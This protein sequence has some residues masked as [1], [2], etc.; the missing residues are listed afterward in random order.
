MKVIFNG[1]LKESGDPSIY[2]SPFGPALEFGQSVFET[3]KV[4]AGRPPASIKEHWERLFK[5]AQILEFQVPPS[6][7]QQTLDSGLAQLISTLDL[8]HEYRCKVLVCADFWWIKAMPLLPF[9]ERHYIEGVVVNEA[10]VQ[11]ILPEAKA[12]S[13]LYSLYASQHSNDGIFETLYFS[14][15]NQ[16]LEGSVSNVIA[17]IDN[18]LVTPNQKVLPGITVREVLKKAQSV[19]LKTE[20]KVVSRGD[21]MKASEIFLTNS[22]KGLVPVKAWNNWEKSSS[23]VYDLLK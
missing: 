23:A 17:V 2:V 20:F 11:R 14:S 21:L 12:A 9:P 16:L 22:I 8:K 13:P 6:L 19:G 15:E 7:K 1:E 5:S 18:V 3:F 4:T 10:V